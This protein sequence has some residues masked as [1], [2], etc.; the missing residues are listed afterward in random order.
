MLA[1]ALITYINANN[2][3]ILLCSV[4]HLISFIT[5][6]EEVEP[7]A[8]EAGDDENADDEG[9]RLL[10]DLVQGDSNAPHHPLAV[11]PVTVLYVTKSVMCWFLNSSTPSIPIPI[12]T[13][14]PTPIPNPSECEDCVS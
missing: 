10:N 13:P 1:S 12:P 2:L 5:K 7:D 4:F 9:E 11:L 6:D 3:S 14:I 8:E